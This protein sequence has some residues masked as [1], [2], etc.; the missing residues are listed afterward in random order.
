MDEVSLGALLLRLAVSMGVVVALMMLAA[1]LLR[2]TVARAGGRGRGGKVRR[3]PIDV[4]AMQPI[5][6][7]AHVAVVRAAGRELVLGV[8]EHQVT[9]LH[10]GIEP[11]DTLEDLDVPADALA[12]AS[13]TADPLTISTGAHDLALVTDTPDHDG[14][15]RHHEHGLTQATHTDRAR[16]AP[17]ATTPA[18]GLPQA[19]TA[20]TSAWTVALE[21]LREKTVRR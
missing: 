7:G 10:S 13:T 14:P 20:S 12:T 9:L 21:M 17:S 15:A 4:A 3:T 1:R 5:T 2:R 11:R 16:I 6:K 18:N 19:G 8:T